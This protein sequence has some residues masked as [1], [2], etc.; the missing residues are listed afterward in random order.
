MNVPL[1]CPRALRG[2]L[3][4]AMTIV[5]MLALA[6]CTQSQTQVRSTGNAVGSSETYEHSL[7]VPEQADRVELLVELEAASGSVT[8]TLVDPFGEVRAEQSEVEGE[9]EG[10]ETFESIPGDWRLAVTF[11]DLSGSY[12]FRLRARW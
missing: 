10:H 6:G 11:E 3:V 8:W 2:V 5:V 4:A 1:P 9:Y 7:P 12:D